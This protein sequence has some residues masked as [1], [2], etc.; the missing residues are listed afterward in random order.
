MMD[1]QCENRRYESVESICVL[2]FLLLLVPQLESMKL[3]L[4]AHEQKEEY[5]EDNWF[6]EEETPYFD[7]GGR[8]LA[9][10]CTHT[11]GYH[12]TPQCLKKYNTISVPSNMRGFCN[13]N[14]KIQKVNQR[15]TT[16]NEFL[17]G[18]NEPSMANIQAAVMLKS[19]LLQDKFT[20][21]DLN[22]NS[23]LL[24]SEKR[25]KTVHRVSS[26]VMA[27]TVFLWIVMDICSQ[28]SII[29]L[30]PKYGP[31]FFWSNFLKL[32]G[33]MAY[34]SA[35]SAMIVVGAPFSGMQSCMLMFWAILMLLTSAKSLTEVYLPLMGII[36]TGCYV[37][38]LKYP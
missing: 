12:S 34:V 2:P 7:M 38:V 11:G 4:E 20:G 25:K 31:I 32:F 18:T 26:F 21:C 23:E 36:L 17:L 16:G 35:T 33:F 28:L 1:P 13:F 14:G 6:L 27:S 29:Q 8:F 19:S 10:L 5:I 3:L 30:Q 9:P 22:K 24:G 15:N 37:L